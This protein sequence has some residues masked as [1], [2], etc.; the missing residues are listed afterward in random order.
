LPPGERWADGA[1]K[2][3]R[4]G[5]EMQ[6]HFG[7]RCEIMHAAQ[8]QAAQELGMR[9]AAGFARCDV[10]NAVCGKCLS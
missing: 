4:A 6:Q 10:R 3:F 9:A 5:G 7:F 2:V 8:K 1:G